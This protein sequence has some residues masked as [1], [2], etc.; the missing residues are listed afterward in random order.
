MADKNILNVSSRTQIMMEHALTLAWIEDP[1][2]DLDSDDF[3]ISNNDE[4]QISEHNTKMELFLLQ[5]FGRS[6]QK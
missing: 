6:T 3:Y 5:R 4:L 1:N 2:S